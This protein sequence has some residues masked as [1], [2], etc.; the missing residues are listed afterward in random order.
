MKYLFLSLFC[1]TSACHQELDYVA[2]SDKISEP[3]I[4][5]TCCKYGL[6]ANAAGGGFYRNVAH[7]DLTFFS[8]IQA[9]VGDARKLYVEMAEDLIARYNSNE[10]IRGFLANFPFE[11]K[12]ICLNIWFADGNP[13]A[14]VNYHESQDKIV[15]HFN[16]PQ[17]FSKFRN[18]EEPYSEAY[19]K[20]F[21]HELSRKPKPTCEI[22]AP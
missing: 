22:K 20:V 18:V 8:N 4:Q 9:T 16:D 17:H 11:Q 3:Y 21:G 10:P 2:L 12:N 5:Q 7:I 1:L 6:R 14:W 19:K 13:L 15:Y